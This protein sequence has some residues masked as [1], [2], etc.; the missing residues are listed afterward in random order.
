MFFVVCMH[1]D[2]F[3][4]LDIYLLIVLTEMSVHREDGLKEKQ[5]PMSGEQD[6]FVS[7]E[8]LFHS[9]KL[10]Y[11]ISFQN[12]IHFIYNISKNNNTHTFTSS[13]SQ[14][15]VRTTQFISLFISEVITPRLAHEFSLTIAKSSAVQVIVKMKEKPEYEINLTFRGPCTVIYSYNKSQHEALFLNFI[16]VMN[17]T[18]FGQST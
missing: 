12:S 16:L 13:S 2:F 3:S 7:F 10:Q 14:L 5:I 6:V 15:A 4:F 9:Y 11:Q 17:S 1:P 8:T 18:C